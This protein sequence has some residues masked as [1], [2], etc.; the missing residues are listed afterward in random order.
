MALAVPRSRYVEARHERATEFGNPGVYVLVGPAESAGFESRIY[1]GESED[2][3]ARIDQHHATKDF[4]NRLVVFTSFG[5][6][7]NKATIRHLEASLLRLAGEAGRAELDN[8]NIPGLPP[9]SEPDRADADSFLADMLVIFPILG[10]NAFEPLARTT[11]SLRLRLS[12]PDAKAEGA[13]TEEG[14]VVYAGALARTETVES[15]HKWAK[16]G[17]NLREELIASGT[18]VPADGGASLRLTTDRLFSSPSA[19]AIVLLGRNAIG[20]LEWKVESGATLKQIR[21]QAVATPD[22]SPDSPES[23]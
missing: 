16:W 17:E 15:L 8:G 4:W 20:L 9:L 11:S 18:L 1:V 6:S 12:G 7:L 5:Q 2:L 23:A 3:R 21:E 10:I 19:A 13:E 14:F 22:S